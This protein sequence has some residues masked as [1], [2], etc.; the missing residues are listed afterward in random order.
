MRNFYRFKM[1]NGDAESYVSLCL[2]K[3]QGMQEYRFYH[4]YK[5]NSPLMIIKVSVIQCF[6]DSISAADNIPIL[7][8]ATETL[9]LLNTKSSLQYPFPADNSQ[10][11]CDDC[12]HKQN[13]DEPSGAI[14]NNSYNPGYD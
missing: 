13:M 3:L 12:Q 5:S 8:T 1:I 10:Q 6:R 7:D 14:V 11:N 9:P 4:W 2:N